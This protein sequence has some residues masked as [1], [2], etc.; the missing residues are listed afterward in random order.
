MLKALFENPKALV[1]AILVHVVLL[2]VL[3]VS[4]DWTSK[5]PAAR[6][7]ETVK[8]VVVD[9]SRVQAEM[10]KLKKAEQKKKDDEAARQK[11]L[12]REAEA[13]KKKRQAEERKLADLKKK[14]SEEA[15]K[16]EALAKQRKAEEQRLAKL[17]QQEE[18][19][20][21][22]EA[23][24]K[25]EA[26]RKAEQAR[27]KR[28]LQEQLQAEAK[29]AQAAEINRYIALIRN[30]VS[31]SWLRPVGFQKGLKCTV[32]VNLIPSGD[33]VN[34]RVTVSSGNPVFDRSVLSAVHKASPLP[35]PKDPVLL[36]EMRVIN[37]EFEPRA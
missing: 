19:R 20:K 1:L 36:N 4:I 5:P 26:Q 9:E 18:V 11:Q 22:E 16:K 37:F 24:K 28:E 3:L 10:E 30:K 25:A 35:L 31:Q 17:K 15:K 29:A 34:A 7:V 13:A 27:R 6:Q 12:K 23:R 33:V 21:K 8:A 14:R 2:G 32:Q